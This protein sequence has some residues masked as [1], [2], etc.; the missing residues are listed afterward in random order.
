[1]KVVYFCF[2]C[3]LLAVIPIKADYVENFKAILESCQKEFPI[4]QDDKE[5]ALAGN[6]NPNP[7]EAFK[8]HLKCVM[9]K[10]DL[11]KNGS[12]N[13]D[14]F[15]EISQKN[16]L[17]KDHLEDIPKIAEKCKSAS[18]SNDCDTAFK[19]TACLMENKGFV[20]PHH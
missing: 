20:M 4:T 18:G 6:L 16:P 11:F 2:T 19:I 14:H 5:K 7:S 8:C 10:K 3:V 15:V 1:M 9:E 17:I 13:V 12:F